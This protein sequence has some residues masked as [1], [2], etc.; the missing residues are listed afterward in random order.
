MDKYMNI[1]EKQSVIRLTPNIWSYLLKI[2]PF[3]SYHSNLIRNSN[4]IKILF[5]STKKLNQFEIFESTYV[6]I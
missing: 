3:R 5:G 1:H 6:T 2:P 4:K